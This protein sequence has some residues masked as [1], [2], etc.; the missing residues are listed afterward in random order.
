MKQDAT[1]PVAT[2]LFTVEM[3]LGS[4]ISRNPLRR[5]VGVMSRGRLEI[6]C[7][8]Q[9]LLRKKELKSSSGQ[10]NFPVKYSQAHTGASVRKE[11]AAH[12]LVWNRTH[13]TV[14]SR[15]QQHWSFV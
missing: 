1:S 15:K 11:G 10:Q 4:T 14:Q 7:R 8:K 2:E 13:K 3:T 6:S 9:S 5:L 12:L